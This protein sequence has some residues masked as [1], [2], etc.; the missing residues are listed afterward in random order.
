[1]A[2]Q[3]RNGNVQRRRRL[4]RRAT[5]RGASACA[6]PRRKVTSLEVDVEVDIDVGVDIEVFSD[7]CEAGD[8]K[9][10][11]SACAQRGE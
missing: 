6:R 7:F 9:R 4:A 10:P 2:T 5:P 8:A 3:L 11:A 1:M